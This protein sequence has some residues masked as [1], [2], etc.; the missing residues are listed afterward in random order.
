MRK[1]DYYWMSNENWYYV[2]DNGVC[3]IKDDAPPEA[4]ESWK[5]YRKQKKMA[6][7]EMKKYGYMD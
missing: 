5:R 4:Q 3:Y 7:E 6:S 1:Y 2:K